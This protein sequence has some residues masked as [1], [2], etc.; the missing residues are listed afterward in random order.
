MNQDEMVRQ[1]VEELRMNETLGRSHVRS[2]ARWLGLQ[3]AARYLLP[4]QLIAGA[5]L[6]IEGFDW[7]GDTPEPSPT[8]VD[9]QIPFLFE[10]WTDTFIDCIEKVELLAAMEFA[11]VTEQIGWTPTNKGTEETPDLEYS[12]RP[13]NMGRLR[14]STC[15]DDYTSLGM[16]LIE[17]RWITFAECAK[18]K[19]RFRC[20]CSGFPRRYYTARTGTSSPKRCMHKDEDEDVDA[21][22][23]V[24]DDDS[25][26]INTTSS[27]EELLTKSDDIPPR[28][29][30]YNGNMMKMEGHTCT[31]PP[32]PEAKPTTPA[33]KNNPYVEDLTILNSSSS[34][35]SD[36]AEPSD[37]HNDNNLCSQE[38]EEEEEEERAEEEQILIQMLDK[39][40]QSDSFQAAA[41][42]LYRV[43]G[44]HW[45]S[46]YEMGE[47]LC[48]SCFLRREGYGEGEDNFFSA[49]PLWF[50]TE[51]ESG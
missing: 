27:E 28:E 21:H 16:G 44:R 40:I 47:R 22:G 48:G 13:Y 23:K 20:V 41:Y 43:Q 8:T 50:R 46:T 17:P 49:I 36:N 2:I 24:D 15:K 26:L 37:H 45:I 38:E 51:A 18:A 6:H 3:I 29:E 33:N 30:K 5:I 19:H 34:A 7:V 35:S 10:R 31:T 12:Q 4:I 25:P 42:Q 1:K 32:N 39:T 9:K 11:R 14:C